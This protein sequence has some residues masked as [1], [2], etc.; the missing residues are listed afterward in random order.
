MSPYKDAEAGKDAAKERKRR[1]RMGPVTPVG[2]E[3]DVTPDS[4][5]GE[6]VTPEGNVT[7]LRSGYTMPT[8]VAAG[9]WRQG[10]CVECGKPVQKGDNCC[11]SCFF[12]KAGG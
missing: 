7:P 3:S 10:T 8:R 9:T 1:Q 6:G 4:T 11:H 2:V 12:G 5:G